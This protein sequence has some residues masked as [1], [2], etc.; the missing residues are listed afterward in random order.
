MQPTT[1]PQVPPYSG[2]RARWP[3]GLTH[4]PQAQPLPQSELAAA[5]QELR[6][7]T[8]NE[9]AEP[10]PCSGL[11]AL[12]RARRVHFAQCDFLRQFSKRGAA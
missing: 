11:Q 2:N 10:L 12:N 7:A 6:E 4:L 9:W 1:F 8:A 5:V 3:A